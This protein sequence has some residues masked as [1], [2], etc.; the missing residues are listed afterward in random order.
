[1]MSDVWCRSYVEKAVLGGG[2]ERFSLFFRLSLNNK[3]DDMTTAELYG[4]DKGRAQRI[5]CCRIPVL[6]ARQW[7]ERASL[8]LVVVLDLL[9]GFSRNRTN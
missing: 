9:S 8:C 7:T 5:P 1:M 6:V 4:S 3:R 2:E